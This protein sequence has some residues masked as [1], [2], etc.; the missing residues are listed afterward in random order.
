MV[1]RS[2]SGDREPLPTRHNHRGR[3][4]GTCLGPSALEVLTAPHST[5]QRVAVSGA[6]GHRQGDDL[7]SAGSHDDRAARPKSADASGRATIPKE[8]EPILAQDRQTER[9]QA[10]H[11]PSGS[12]GPNSRAEINLG[13]RYLQRY[14]RRA[15][16]GLG[17]STSTV[18]R[19]AAIARRPSRHP[20]DGAGDVPPPN[21]SVG[22][23]VTLGGD[24][25]P[26]T[27]PVGLGLGLG[28]G[29]GVTVGAGVGWGIGVGVG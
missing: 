26:A 4:A 17:V 25:T 8:A 19:R 5:A 28:D 9:V 14:F 24:V 16:F 2:R 3:R 21:V 13:R 27:S 6:S 1:H 7:P 23:N 20:S 22:G 18:A 11:A 29:L 15:L 12:R 10:R